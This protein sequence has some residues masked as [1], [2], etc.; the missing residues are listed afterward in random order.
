MLIKLAIFFIGSLSA[1]TAYAEVYDDPQSPDYYNI[2][3][4]KPGKVKE[5]VVTAPSEKSK[6]RPTEDCTTFVMTP[7][8]VKYFFRHARAVSERTQM[9]ELDWSACYAEGTII[10]DN[11]DIGTWLIARYGSGALSLKNGKF[12][13]KTVFFYCSKCDDWGL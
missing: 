9:H 13:G 8:L 10:F 5:A 6:I 1:L 3:P 12:K 7:K 2:I 11:K 4:Y